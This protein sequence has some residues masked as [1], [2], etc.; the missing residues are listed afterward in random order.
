MYGRARMNNQGTLGDGL[1]NLVLES[2]MKMSKK[3]LTGSIAAAIAAVGIGFNSAANAELG[4]VAG[5]SNMYFWRGL[6]VSDGP[7][8]WADLKYSVDAGFYGGVWVSSEG[9]NSDMEYDLYAGWSKTFGDFGVDIGAV[10]YVYPSVSDEQLG[11]ADCAGNAVCIREKTDIRDPGN[12]TDAYIALSAY[13]VTLKYLDNVA[14]VTGE[15]YYTL[16]YSMAPFTA[17]VGYHDL[18]EGDD[19]TY[20]HIDLTYAFSENLTFTVSQVVD[21]DDNSGVDNRALV[22]VGYS[23][24]I[25]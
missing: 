15:E 4:A 12:F 14:D 11:V 20:T 18:G 6:D 3:L 8:V 9:F 10:T 16:S 7:Q 1:F 23:L 24:P 21:R 19:D 5:V 2:T 22:V 25:K 17:L 13:G